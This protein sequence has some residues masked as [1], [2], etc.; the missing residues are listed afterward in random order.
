M[1]EWLRS[2]EGR[3]RREHAGK[4]GFA[5]NLET[6]EIVD[7][8]L[9]VQEE[10]GQRVSNIVFMVSTRCLLEEPVI[11][12]CPLLPIHLSSILGPLHPAYGI[13]LPLL[14]GNGRATSQSSSR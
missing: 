13:F 12:S 2:V 5:R 7:Q 4:G 6:H 3:A 11:L 10:F 9:T 14:T 1:T 8:V